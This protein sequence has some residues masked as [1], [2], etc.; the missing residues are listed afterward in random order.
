MYEYLGLSDESYSLL[1]WMGMVLENVNLMFSHSLLPYLYF[2]HDSFDMRFAPE[3]WT[4][5]NAR[6]KHIIV[7]REEVFE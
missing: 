3:N 2:W 1:V 4:L 5:L 6:E 7:M